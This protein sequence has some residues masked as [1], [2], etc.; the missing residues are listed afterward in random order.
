M[1]HFRIMG[2][3]CDGPAE[4]IDTAETKDEADYLEGEYELAFGGSW[5]IW[6]ETQEYQDGTLV[7]CG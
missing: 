1:E 5:L 6:T 4:E 2:R 7:D 3:Y